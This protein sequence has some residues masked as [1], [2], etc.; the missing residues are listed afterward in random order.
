MNKNKSLFLSLLIIIALSLCTACEKSSSTE[1]ALLPKEHYGD[2]LQMQENRKQLHDFVV[3]R[4]TGDYGVLVNYLDTD[5]AADV[6][7]GHEVLSESSGIL[8]RYYALTEQQSAFDAEWELTKETFDLT[9]GFSYRYS[10]AHHKRYPVNAAVDD[11]R[12]IRALYEAGETFKD[13]RYTEEANRYGARFY[14][15]NVKDGYLYDFYDDDYHITNDFI[16]LC[17]IDLK[18]LR[19]LPT[20]SKQNQELSANMQHIIHN[21]YLSDEFPFYETR[22]QYETGSYSSENIHTVESLLTIL[23]LAEVRQQQ[24]ASIRYLKEQVNAGTLFGQ[25][26]KDGTPL[27][28]VQSTAIYAIAAMIGSELQDQELYSDSIMRMNQF[29]VQDASHSLNGGFADIPTEQAYSFDNLMALLA[30]SY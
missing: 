3:N 11:L 5:Q 27:N 1:L 21:G 6:A 28:D 12:I 30:Y 19:L 29:Q 24:E 23:S 16:T 7:T 17:Y 9:T 22:Y 13:D 4:L 15:F 18:S 14:Q 10:P 25:Y 2:M 26:A 8:L 20:S